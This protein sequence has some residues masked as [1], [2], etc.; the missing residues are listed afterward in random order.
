MISN[1]ET[2]R[3]WS[4]LRVSQQNHETWKVCIFIE[5]SLKQIYETIFLEGESLGKS[6]LSMVPKNRNFGFPEDKDSNGRKALIYDF[7]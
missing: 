4:K 1:H 5:L 3:S 6:F 2:M 7:H